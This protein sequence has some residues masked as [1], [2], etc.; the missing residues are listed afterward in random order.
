MF[1]HI[2]VRPQQVDARLTGDTVVS[3][4]SAVSPTIFNI[5]FGR[6]WLPRPELTQRLV[7][8]CLPDTLWWISNVLDDYILWDN[9]NVVFRCARNAPEKMLASTGLPM[10]FSAGILSRCDHT[11]YQHMFQHLESWVS[12][13]QHQHLEKSKSTYIQILIINPLALSM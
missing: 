8:A 13:C 1:Q 11:T 3:A 7:R 2:E 5:G 10:D 4:V 12:T 6:V 9:I